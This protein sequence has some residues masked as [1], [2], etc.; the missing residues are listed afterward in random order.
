MLKMDLIDLQ[1]RLEEAIHH[2]FEAP[3]WVRAE[4]NH[5][6]LSKGIVIWNWCKKTKQR[7]NWLPKPRLSFGQPVCLTGTVFRTSTGMHLQAGIQVLLSVEPNMHPLYGLSLVVLNIDPSYTMGDIEAEK[8]NNRQ[9]CKEGIFDM[10]K[11]LPFPAVPL[12]LAVISSPAAAGIKILPIIS[13]RRFAF[14]TELFTALMQEMVLGKYH[15]GYGGG[16][17]TRYLF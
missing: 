7:T 9:A 1:K 17:G 14:R 4:I 15:R 12:K 2:A 10:N 13:K 5:I 3:C 11:Q 8:K 16:P 6:S